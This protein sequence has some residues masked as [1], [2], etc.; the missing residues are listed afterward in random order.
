MNASIPSPE[1]RFDALFSGQYEVCQEQNWGDPYAPGR[2][3]EI[4]MANTLGHKVA[5]TLSG[6]DAYEDEAMT[7]PVEYK[8]TTGSLKGTY[9]GI[10]VKSTWDEQ[11]Q[12]LREGKICCYVRHYFARYE[13]ANIVE[14]W[15]LDCETVLNGLLDRIQD[16]FLRDRNGADPR[17][18][19]I[20]SG[21][22]IRNHGTQ[23]R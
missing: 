16:Q 6:A 2:A 1:A 17:L 9:N 23:I 19:A 15:C 11:L 18:G 21:T 13:G 8:S 22:Y 3:R 14:L 4:H 20:L 5:P 7:I 12:Y 10:S